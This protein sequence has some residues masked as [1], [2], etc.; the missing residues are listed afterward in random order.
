M[1]KACIQVAICIQANFLAIFRYL[2]PE[3]VQV[4]IHVPYID[5]S[6]RD[7]WRPEQRAGDCFLVAEQGRSRRSAEY[8]EV[9]AL[10]YHKQSW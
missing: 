1:K 9:A 2:K 6:V 8:F 3:S 7:N 5:Y 4:S 10:P